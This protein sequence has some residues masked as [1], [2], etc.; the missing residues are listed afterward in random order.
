[1]PD[2][3]CSWN[4]FQKNT[5]IQGV[6]GVVFKKDA[7]IQGVV[8]V[9]FKKNAQIQGVVGVVFKKAQRK[10]RAVRSTTKGS[11]HP[12]HRDARCL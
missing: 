7:Q 9:V 2:T 8:G 11:V 10:R 3:G 6:V 12:N 1:M 4:G 5:Q